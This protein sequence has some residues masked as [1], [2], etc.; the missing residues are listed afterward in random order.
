MEVSLNVDL[1]INSYNFEYAAIYLEGEAAMHIDAEGDAQA[2]TDLTFST[3]MTTL[4]LADTAFAVGP[5]PFVIQ[6][7]VPVHAGTDI[8][9]AE[10]GKVQ[11]RATMNGDIKYGLQ[12]TQ[13]DGFQYINSHSFTHTGGLTAADL[14]LRAVAQVNVWPVV[15]IQID[16]IGGPTVGVK[17]FVESSVDAQQAMCSPTGGYGTSFTT[18]W[19]AQITIGGALDIGFAGHTFL[20]E[21]WQSAPIWSHKWPVAAGCLAKPQNEGGRPLGVVEQPTLLPALADYYEFFEGVQYVGEILIDKSNPRCDQLVQIHGGLQFVNQSEHGFPGWVGVSLNNNG[22]VSSLT[23]YNIACIGQHFY[24]AD[25]GD[26]KH[27]IQPASE[28]DVSY[29]NCTLDH[30][31]QVGV[32]L[33]NLEGTWG[34]SADIGTL[35]VTPANR[36]ILPVTLHREKRPTPGDSRTLTAAHSRPH[37]LVWGFATQD[38]DRQNANAKHSKPQL[39]NKQLVALLNGTHP[40]K[41]ASINGQPVS[42]SPA[43]DSSGSGSSIMLGAITVL[44]L[45]LTVVAVALVMSRRKQASLKKQ[46]LGHEQGSSPYMELE[47]DFPVGL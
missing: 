47:G 27:Y 23:D 20:D 4:K 32:T 37:D 24:V 15:V 17:G 11:A 29:K 18:S 21:H 41:M 46:L 38:P 33:A 14:E 12:Y 30:L 39:S 28:P 35:T 31:D 36:C 19:G 10:N 9:A 13:G 5:V 40:S 6:T 16:H 42:S 44:G 43:H 22:R 45:L 2:N 3:L 7:T 26:L 34:L 1:Q 25:G 8:T